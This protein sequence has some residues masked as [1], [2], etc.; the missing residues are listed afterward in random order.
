MNNRPPSYINQTFNNVYV[1]TQ[2]LAF[3]TYIN[4][5]TDIYCAVL[6]PQNTD[7][8]N[9]YG[10]IPLIAT[11]T[12]KNTLTITTSNSQDWSDFVTNTNPLV[13]ST[14][15]A[16]SNT[17]GASLLSSSSYQSL[18]FSFNAPFLSVSNYSINSSTTITNNWGIMIMMNPNIGFDS[19]A[20]VTIKESIATS[21]LIPS[22]TTV[23]NASSYNLYTMITLRGSTSGA[24]Q[25]SFQ[26]AN[27]KTSFGVYPFRVNPFSSIY[28]D[29]NNMDFMIATVDGIDGPL[30]K[31]K[32][33]GY[34]M[35][36]GFSQSTPTTTIK[37]G[38]VNYQYPSPMD[39]S[40]VPTVLRIKGTISNNASALNSLVVFFDKLTPFFSN[41]QSG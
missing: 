38:F 10:A 41:M 15:T 32:F 34:F 28:S 6:I 5:F 31:M 25:T 14:S 9:G 23:T 19:N 37:M 8:V 22:V 16:S 24:L 40:Q 26:V 35:I 39:G 30:N 33:I 18:I 21:L 27:V 2:N 3:L 11:T 20:T 13:S 7:I 36:N 1:I 17:P 29:S 4:L 12:P